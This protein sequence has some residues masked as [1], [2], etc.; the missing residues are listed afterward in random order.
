MKEAR[1]INSMLSNWKV[2]RSGSLINNLLLLLEKGKE[3]KAN[4][5]LE[6]YFMFSLI[7]VSHLCSLSLEKRIRI[8]FCM[9]ISNEI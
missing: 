7:Q 3:G 8:P 6:I 9:V 2:K 1:H 4:K 5:S